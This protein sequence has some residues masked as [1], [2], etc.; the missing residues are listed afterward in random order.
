[1]RCERSGPWIT[2]RK[3][4]GNLP[5]GRQDQALQK[6]VEQA[7]RHVLS[8]SLQRIYVLERDAELTLEFWFQRCTQ[9]EADLCAAAAIRDAVAVEPDLPVPSPSASAAAK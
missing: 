9:S 1:M 4:L 2:V 3:S 5:P 8:T 7:E 6:I